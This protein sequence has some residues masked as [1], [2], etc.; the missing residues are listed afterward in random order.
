MKNG[1][2]CYHAAGVG[3]TYDPVAHQQKFFNLHT[4]D[5]TCIAFSPDGVH[6][7]T[8]ENGKKPV[9]YIWN[10]ETQTLKSKLTGNGIVQNIFTIAYSPSGNHLAII[11]ESDDHNIA[12]YDT[13]T[14]ACISKSKGDRALIQSCAWLD[15][16]TF[17]TVGPKHFKQWTIKSGGFASKLGNFGGAN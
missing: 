15:E 6:V 10:S 8:G 14:G 4:D 11:D 12:V 7:A 1:S 13:N 9:C 16:Q 17:V 2:L 3:V 5:I